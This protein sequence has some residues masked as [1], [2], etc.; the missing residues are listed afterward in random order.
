[1][2][3]FVAD[4]HFGDAPF[5]K[6]RGMS[7][8]GEMDDVLVTSWNSVVGDADTVFILGDFAGDSSRMDEYLRLL[9]GQKHL[10]IGNH[11]NYR[12]AKQ[13][14][15]L[16]SIE[17]YREVLFA[18]QTVILLHY[19]IRTWSSMG[20]G[21]WHLHGHT[22]GSLALNRSLP[23]ADVGVDSGYFDVP[24]GTPISFKQLDNSYLRPSSRKFKG[25]KIHHMRSQNGS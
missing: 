5:V 15:E 8:V 3:F 7:S 12:D 22:H 2:L 23:R 24:F 9:K 10:I 17:F 14:Q 13:S 1:M 11:D 19:P 6:S 20:Q 21:A 25:R 18:R 16:I 4:T